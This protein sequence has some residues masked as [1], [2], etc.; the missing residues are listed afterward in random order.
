MPNALEDSVCVSVR[1]SLKKRKWW[2]VQESN[3]ASNSKKIKYLV[4]FLE[5]LRSTFA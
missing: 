3:G 4:R 2:V 1:V 5:N